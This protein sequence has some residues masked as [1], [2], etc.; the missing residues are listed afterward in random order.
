VFA[1]VAQAGI[2]VVA[3]ET[4]AHL[5][6]LDLKFHLNRNT[7]ALSR[8]IDRGVR[9]GR[10]WVALGSKQTITHKHIYIHGELRIMSI[11]CPCDSR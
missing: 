10:V 1:K 11:D 2:R 7:G 5:H 3:R 8:S 9:Y 4:F 6:S